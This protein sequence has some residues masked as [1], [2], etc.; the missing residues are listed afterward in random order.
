V[1]VIS[2][3]ERYDNETIHI[4]RASGFEIVGRVLL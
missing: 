3:N 4:G 2:D 1:R